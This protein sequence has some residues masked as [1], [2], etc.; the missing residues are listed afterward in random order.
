MDSLNQHLHFLIKQILNNAQHGLEKHTNR[1]KLQSP[2]HSLQEKKQQLEMTASHLFN[3]QQQ[4]INN[5][6]KRLQILA[7]K[8]NSISPLATLERGYSI[9]MDT[10]TNQVIY[11]SDDVHSGQNIKTKLKDAEIFSTVN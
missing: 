1:L 10:E 11:S 5:K 7:A 2:I 3:H 6:Q 9:T 4:Q 8:L